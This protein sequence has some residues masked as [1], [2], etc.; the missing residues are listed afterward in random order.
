MK[1]LWIIVFA[2][3]SLWMGGCAS[4]T[5]PQPQGAQSC[6]E[7]SQTQKAW[8]VAQKIDYINRHA[9]NESFEDI[10]VDSYGNSY[11]VR[12][13]KLTK[14]NCH[15]KEVWKKQIHKGRYTWAKSLGID[16]DYVYIVYQS[17][18]ITVLVK[19]DFD[20]HRFFIGKYGFDSSVSVKSMAIDKGGNI[21]LVAAP[22]GGSGDEGFVAKYNAKGKQLWL[23]KYLDTYFYDVAID[24][25]GDL[26]VVGDYTP[27]K[28]SMKASIVIK[29]NSAGKIVWR[30]TFKHIDKKDTVTFFSVDI[31]KHN[32]FYVSGHTSWYDAY[33]LKFTSA[34]KKVWSKKAV[35]TGYGMSAGSSVLC[36]DDESI[37]IAGNPNFF[38]YPSGYK[39]YKYH[40]AVA[41]YSA[42]GKLLARRIASAYERAYEKD[43]LMYK[44]S[45]YQQYKRD[46]G[47]MYI[48]KD[49]KIIYD[50]L[51]YVKPL[52]QEEY[53]NRLQIIDGEHKAHI[54]FIKAKEKQE[55]LHTPFI[56][57]NGDIIEHHMQIVPDANKISVDAYFSNTDNS[58]Y[59]KDINKTHHVFSVSSTKADAL[60]FHTY[61]KNITFSENYDD[62]AHTVYYKKG[63][64]YGFAGE[65]KVK[66][67]KDG[68][69]Y[70]FV[71]STNHKKYD[72]IVFDE[73]G[74][75][76]LQYKGLWGYHNISD[77]KYKTLNAFEESL[78]RVELPNAKKGY[79]DLKGNE[80]VE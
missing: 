31:D 9:N 42:E 1:K 15:H 53:G 6:Y 51:T 13:E 19:Y 41:K 56:C 23:H 47:T 61:K 37:Y 52:A 21:I 33:L 55:L 20:G 32:H 43:R 80:Y 28:A 27:E 10:V 39:G 17:N 26:I 73:Y 77:E 46:D 4:H 45:F 11:I 68:V 5:N 16:H 54:V 30:K 57:G 76:R 50:H 36:A 66:R 14:Y 69:K 34:G 8:E 2:G 58:D 62:T 65:V 35:I 48:V 7:T 72:A 44:S 74:K 75:V 71:K 3:V 67:E 24:K 78:A 29:Y 63:K 25:N 59:Q 49:G 60:F 18:M 38:L 64:Q 79:I 70:L 22:N 40:I 12:D